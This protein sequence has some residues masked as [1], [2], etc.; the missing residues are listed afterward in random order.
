MA[1]EIE[2]ENLEAHVE[3]CAERYGQLNR[4]LTIIEEKVETILTE[5]SNNNRNMQRVVIGATGTVIAGLLSTIVTLLM[6]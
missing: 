5:L 6:K 2:K 3:L 1:T 4:R